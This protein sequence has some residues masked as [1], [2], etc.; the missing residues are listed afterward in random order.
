[1][2]NDDTYF[3]YRHKNTVTRALSR[4]FRRIAVFET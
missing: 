3:S 4:K 1:M 2:K